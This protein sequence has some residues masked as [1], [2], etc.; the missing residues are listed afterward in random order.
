MYI[1]K[2]FEETRTEV[3]TE[4]IQKHALGCLILYTGHTYKHT[5]TQTKQT[6][7]SWPMSLMKDILTYKHI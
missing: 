3:L 4:L 5:H 7:F 6:I 2:V 1:P